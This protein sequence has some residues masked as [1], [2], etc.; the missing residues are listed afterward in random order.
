M[1]EQVGAE[2]TSRLESVSLTEMFAPAIISDRVTGML[3]NYS[4]VSKEAL[5]YFDLVR[6]FGNVPEVTTPITI[7]SVSLWL[8]DE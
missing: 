5:A 8:H 4:F 2:A 6:I 3:A 7:A 1:T